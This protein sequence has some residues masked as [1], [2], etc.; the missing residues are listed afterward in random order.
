MIGNTPSKTPMAKIELMVEDFDLKDF[1][2]IHGPYRS[3]IT[4][5]SIGRDRVPPCKKVDVF[6]PDQWFVEGLNW[7]TI[8]T[9][10]PD[11]S[12]SVSL[13]SQFMEDL[14]KG[15]LDASKHV[16]AWLSRTHNHGLQLTQGEQFTENLMCLVT[17]LAKS[18]TGV[19]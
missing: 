18:C 9:S 14:S 10:C 2:V 6:K 4:M 16:Q 13:L 11:L 19:I 15:H 17:A 12:M 7:L 3:S 1:N 5:N 8:T